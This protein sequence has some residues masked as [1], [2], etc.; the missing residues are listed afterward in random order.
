[1]FSTADSRLRLMGPVHLAILAAIPATAALLARAGRANPR[2]ARRIR[3]GL[4]AL[5]AANEA[6]WYIREYI[7]GGLRFPYGLPLQLCDLTALLTV[8]AAFTLAQWC[9]EFAYF[10]ALAGSGMAVL[11]PDLWA[12]AAS[13]ATVFFF[14]F[15]GLSIVTVLTMLWQGDARPGQGAVWRAFAL[16]NAMA[17]AIGVFDWKFGTNY[18]FLRAKPEHVSL[19][20]VLGPWPVYI[21]AADALALALFCL[22]AL[23]F[24]ARMA[25]WPDNWWSVCRI[26]RK[27][28]TRPGS[29]RS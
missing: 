28:G 4:G 2:I 6:A 23:P 11:T 17:A 22:L 25:T 16:L 15:H 3:I 19:L 9:F 7:S 24:R 14:L 18:A 12:P 10:G 29:T 20:S 21:F 27:G 13:Y 5:L 26:F 8:V 1:V